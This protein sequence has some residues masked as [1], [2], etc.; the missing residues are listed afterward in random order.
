M[1]PPIPLKSSPEKKQSTVAS[2]VA[3]QTGPRAMKKVENRQPQKSDAEIRAKIEELKGGNASKRRINTSNK[4][5]SEFMKPETI[6][7]PETSL[8]PKEKLEQVQTPAVQEMKEAKP[9][10]PAAPTEQVKNAEQ[11]PAADQANPSE[12]VKPTEGHVLKS[13]VGFNSPSDPATTEKLKSL[14]TSGGFNFN[15]KERAALTKIL[16]E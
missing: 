7:P 15:E 16:G 1:G 2:P 3:D 13:D 12:P 6:K 4:Q 5:T 8:I 14:L 11:T 9:V 10:A